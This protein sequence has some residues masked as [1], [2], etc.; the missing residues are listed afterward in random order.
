MTTDERLHEQLLLTR[1]AEI[2]D[3]S[4]LRLVGLWN[5]RRKIAHLA[6]VG[7]D[8]HAVVFAPGTGCGLHDL[9]SLQRAWLRWMLSTP[10][11]A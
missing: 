7:L 5:P 3:R 2:Q 11:E 9:D 1:M 10:I 4:G 6:L 8:G